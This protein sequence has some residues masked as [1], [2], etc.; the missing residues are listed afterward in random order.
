MIDWISRCPT[1]GHRSLR[2]HRWCRASV[3]LLLVGFASLA[4]P[5]AVRAQQRPLLTEDPRLVPDGEL[6]LE[7]GLGYFNRARFPV[8][9]LEGNQLSVLT[10][11]AYFG[12]GRHAEFALTG[13]L[14]DFLWIDRGDRDRTNDW[15]D[16]AVSTKIGLLGESG[17]RPDV[18]FQT[19]IVLPNASNESGLGTDGTHFFAK[20]LVGKSFGASYVFGNIG[21]GILDDAVR[22]AAQQD[23]LVYGLA[24]VVPIFED[25]ELAFEVNGRENPQSNPT[26]GGE[27]RAQTRLGIRW[28]ALD[29][30]WDAGLTAGLTDLDHRVGLVVGTTKR[31]TLWR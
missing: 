13:T 8:S 7:N 23:V 24:A 25:V 9:G 4:V 26:L 12:L 22:A 29:M 30:E 14:H 28:L 20:I 21:L 5:D 6:V 18:S 19:S 27:D 1:R 2:H 15:G 31:F 16:G 3:A 17:R 10:G 11:G